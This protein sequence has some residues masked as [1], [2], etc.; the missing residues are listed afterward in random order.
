MVWLYYVWFSVL[1]VSGLVRMVMSG[2]V[3]LVMSGLVCPSSRLVSCTQ[4]TSAQLIMILLLH[5]R[6]SSIGRNSVSPFVQ[7]A[8]SLAFN[9]TQPNTTQHNF[10]R[11]VLLLQSLFG[12]AQ[13]NLVM[14]CHQRVLL[15]YLTAKEARSRR[16][17]GG[18]GGK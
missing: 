8:Q 6:P 15:K 3:H 1:A 11:D 14:H 10:D 13:N 5:S 9:T 7:W 4:Q 16:R 12:K 17:L 2:L 18:P